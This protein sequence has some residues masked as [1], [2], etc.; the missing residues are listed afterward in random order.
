MPPGRTSCPGSPIFSMKTQPAVPIHYRHQIDQSVHHTGLGCPIRQSADKYGFM[1]APGF[2]RLLNRAT[3][4]FFQPVQLHFQLPDLPVQ[5]VD[6]GLLLPF[7]GLPIPAERLGDDPQ[8]FL[9]PWS[10]LVGNDPGLTG[11]LAEG[12]LPPRTASNATFPL[13]WI[14]N[15]CR[16]L[17]MKEILQACSRP[18]VFPS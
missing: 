17:V 3:V 11:E 4:L 8:D 7:P 5:L 12:F 18:A 1:R 6:Q 10:D 16:I 13:K 2:P 9:Y 15:R 14:S